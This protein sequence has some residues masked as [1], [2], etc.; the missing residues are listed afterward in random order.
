[1]QENKYKIE[2]LF[3]GCYRVVGM[4]SL[5]NPKFI[6]IDG[7]A[8]WLDAGYKNPIPIKTVREVGIDLLPGFDE[9]AHL[10]AYDDFIRESYRQ[11]KESKFDSN[12]YIHPLNFVR[13]CWSYNSYLSRKSR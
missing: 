8:Q 5:G 4:A 2:E 13:K 9:E 6:L 12:G 11:F 3:Q 10:E 7:I 1:M